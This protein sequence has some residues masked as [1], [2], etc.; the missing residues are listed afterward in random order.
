[1]LA[2]F[3][4]F[5]IIFPKV[6]VRDVGPLRVDT[7]HPRHQVLSLNEIHYPGGANSRERLPLG[8]AKIDSKQQQKFVGFKEKNGGVS[9]RVS[10]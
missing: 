3:L 5:F 8:Q 10:W 9:A 1:M 7:G 4:P 2:S 6:D